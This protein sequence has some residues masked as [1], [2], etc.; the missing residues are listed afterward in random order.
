MKVTTK[1]YP[2]PSLQLVRV[3]VSAPS[4]SKVVNL[5]N[6]YLV[7]PAEGA[8]ENALDLYYAYEFQVSEMVSHT[9]S[10]Q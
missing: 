4:G 8:A 5:T 2:P 9:L 3:K 10:I 7:P 6:S 1:P